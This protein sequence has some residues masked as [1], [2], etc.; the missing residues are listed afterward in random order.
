MKAITFKNIK[1]Q[2][3]PL[4]WAQQAGVRPD[5]RVN[6]TIQSCISK[7]A[8]RQLDRTAMQQVLDEVKALPVLDNRTPDEIIGYDGNGLLL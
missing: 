1:G 4:E 7:K 5:E 6:I 8:R 3:L 2:E